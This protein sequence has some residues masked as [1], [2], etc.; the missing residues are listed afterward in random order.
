MLSSI[1]FNAIRTQTFLAINIQ[2]FFM[3]SVEASTRG[4]WLFTPP[5][6]SIEYDMGQKKSENI[7]QKNHQQS[8]STVYS[9]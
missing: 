4:V 2:E 9:N 1:A 8:L 6:M 3:E 7:L 5:K